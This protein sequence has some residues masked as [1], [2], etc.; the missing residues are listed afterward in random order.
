LYYAVPDRRFGFD[1]ARPLTPFEHLVRDD[2]LGSAIS[3]LEH[4]E[5]W[6][7][8]VDGVT[9]PDEVAARIRT[10]DKM[11]YSIHFHVWDHQSFSDFLE[12]ARRYLGQQFVVDHLERNMN[13]VVAILRKVSPCGSRGED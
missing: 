8:S 12:E 9:N 11:N 13:E 3:R 6:V 4:L 5:E 2:R 10:L 1:A 7:R